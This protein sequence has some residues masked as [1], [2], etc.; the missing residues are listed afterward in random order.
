MTVRKY[1]NPAREAGRALT[2]L[3]IGVALTGLVSITPTFA[4]EQSRLEG[5]KMYR[6]GIRPSG[7]PVTALVAGDVPILGTQFSCQN[8]HGR[9]GMGGAEA[10]YIVPPI[11]GPFLFA[12]S[13][14]PA[15]PAYDKDS[16]ARLMREGVT[17]SGR[18]MDPLMPRYLLTD[19][20]MASL[21]DYLATLSAGN[22]PGVDDKVIR[23]ATVVTEQATPEQRA[24]V[25]AVIETFA[26]EKNRQT[27]LEGRRLDRGSTP[28]SKLPTVFREWKVEQWTLTGPSEGWLEQLENLYRDTPVFALL[29]GL[30]PDSWGPMGRFCET[31]EIPC[32]LPGTGAPQA[33]KNDFYTLHFS[34]GLE[35]EADLVATHLAKHPAP[36]VFQVHCDGQAVAA[37]NELESSLKIAGVATDTITV[38]CSGSI[39]VD[40]VVSPLRAQAGVATVLWLNRAQLDSLQGALPAGPLYLSSTLLDGQ[41]E[42]LSS[43]MSALTFLVHP[44]RLPGEADSALMRFRAWAK[45]RGIEVTH[46]RLQAEAFFACLATS[47]AVAHLGRFFVRDYVLDMLDHAQGLAA[48]VPAYPRPSLGP[49]QRFLSKGG[50]ILPIKDGMPDTGDALWVVP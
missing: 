39:D 4:S 16:L 8:C 10:T 21:A 12:E 7:E 14:Q 15:R 18:I 45:G 46:P 17:P 35:L 47:D 49:G 38:D 37:V 48:Y 42:G 50:Y 28:S 6:E 33:Q 27:R 34:R 3:I 2:A 22:S 26:G 23:F 32:L 5:Q 43:P 44:Y 9:S 11:A 31:H 36:A 1:V 41:F 30:S 25:M 40:D 19:E 20:E 13:P 24:A 29:G